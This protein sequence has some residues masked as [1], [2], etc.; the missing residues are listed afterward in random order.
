MTFR[1]FKKANIETLYYTF[2]ILFMISIYFVP[3]KT[4]EILF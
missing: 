2:G 3:K 4:W 1:I